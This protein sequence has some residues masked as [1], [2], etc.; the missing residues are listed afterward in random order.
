MVRDEERLLPCT[1][2]TILGVVQAIIAVAG[3][4]LGLP[5]PSK[6]H[7]VDIHVAPQPTL[8]SSG[9]TARPLPLPLWDAL[10]SWVLV[11]AGL[12]FTTAGRG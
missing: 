3:Q 7:S 8:A 12:R 2:P 6:M 4:H 9:A 1:T 10:V 11:M 5:A